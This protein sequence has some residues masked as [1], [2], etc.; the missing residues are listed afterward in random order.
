MHLHL[1]AVGGM[2][3]DM[4]VAALLDAFPDH[5]A[6]L[7]DSIG[8]VAGASV[9]CRRIAHSDGVLQGSRFLVEEQGQDHPH[10]DHPHHDHAHHDRPHHDHRRDD[11]HHA[12]AHHHD[13][14]HHHDA[15]RHPAHPH[16][17][18]AEIRAALG[19]AGLAPAVAGHA[20]A[21]FGHL[22]EAE[23]R[24][25]GIPVDEVAFH[26]VGSWDSIADIVGAAHL[27]AALSPARWSVGP[28]PLGSGRVMTAHGP[29]PVPAP[30]TALLL[31]G[32]AVIDDGVP[33]ERVTPTG[34]AILR[35]L[36]GGG[37]PAAG[38]RM[39][40]RSGIGFGTRR[41]PG[42]SNCLRVLAFEEGPG[43]GAGR[44]RELGVIEFEVD[45][46]SAEDLATG[47]ERLRAH[48]AVHDVVQAPVFGK[49]GRMMTHIR[50]LARAEALDAVIEACFRETTTIGLRHHVVAGAALPRRSETV[51]LDGRPVRVKSVER[52]GGRTAKAEADDA[53]GDTHAARAAFRRAAERR[54]LDGEPS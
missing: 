11:P 3:G 50:V 22:A 25:H 40:G 26:E 34:A 37:N 32:F 24:V 8:R 35:H 53:A 45:D 36:C 54:A 15:P 38:P 6:G 12:H 27:I 23:G 31:Q 18:W 2:A 29:L 9:A 4:F 41:L 44:H 17:H 14:P 46:Q 30:A 43:P 10:H 47:I 13:H 5:E 33:G 19:G 51:T 48:E 42:L 39:M 16:R 20:L 49:K 1:D 7:L 21:I 52:P 28:L